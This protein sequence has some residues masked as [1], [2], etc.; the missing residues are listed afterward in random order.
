[1]ASTSGMGA[2]VTVAVTGAES[3]RVAVSVAITVKPNAS[4]VSFPGRRSCVKLMVVLPMAAM[5]NRAVPLVWRQEYFKGLLLAP[6]AVIDTLVPDSTLRAAMGETTGRAAVAAVTVMLM[7]FVDFWL[8]QP[9][10]LRVNKKVFVEA[11]SG[12][13]NVG[14]AIVDEGNRTKAGGTTP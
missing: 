11:T 1:M 14:F 13:L 6:T 2:T 12:A 5:N 3:T 4:F 8:L 10:T 7:T 9:N